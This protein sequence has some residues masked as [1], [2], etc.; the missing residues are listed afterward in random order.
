MFKASHQNV[1]DLLILLLLLVV[2]LVPPEVPGCL[3]MRP[4]VVQV[5][6]PQ[7]SCIEAQAI[8][9]LLGW[10]RVENV[11]GRLV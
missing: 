7:I 3:V 8:L 1:D 5:K 2:P 6:C 11:C 4:W 10:P 9:L